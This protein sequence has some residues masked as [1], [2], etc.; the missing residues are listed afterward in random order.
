[1]FSILSYPKIAFR[2]AFL[3]IASGAGSFRARCV[4]A[5]A[6]GALRCPLPLDGIDPKAWREGLAMPVQ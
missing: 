6:T 4:S 5:A 3:C 2:P 1:M